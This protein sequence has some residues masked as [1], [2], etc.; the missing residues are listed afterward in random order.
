[1]VLANRV[2][3]YKR[4]GWTFAKRTPWVTVP[5]ALASSFAGVDLSKIKAFGIDLSTWDGNV[6]WKAVKKAGVQ[7]AILRVGHGTSITDDQIARNVR[8]CLSVG[9]KYGVYYYST[10]RTVTQAKKEASHALSIMKSAGIT[11]S[12][13]DYAVFYDLEESSLES[14]KNRK[15]LANLAS[16][17]LST[18][19]RNGY[20][21]GVYANL[22]WWNNYLTDSS[23]NN[24]QRWVAQWKQPRCAY[25]GKYTFWQ[26][27]DNGRVPG[28]A[29]LVDMDV[30]Y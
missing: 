2:T 16:A 11:K 21:V 14:T 20:K 29:G 9:I 28:I 1:M 12:N 25:K 24:Y 22:N 15:L 18:M 26:T 23:F 30:M 10:A 7:F 13:M 19:K 5:K 17:F 4:Q 3:G 6:D 27:R 8:G